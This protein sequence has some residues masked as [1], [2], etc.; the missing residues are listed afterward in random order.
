[1]AVVTTHLAPACRGQHVSTP[2]Y[3]R[4]RP[5][6]TVLYRVIQET[7]RT[8]LDLCEAEGRPLP[9]FVQKEFEK[10]LACGILSEGFC[11]V[12]CSQC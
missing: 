11:R 5:E 2:A 8:F 9:A 6:E 3:E 12:L 7:Y 10:F 4:H 1:M